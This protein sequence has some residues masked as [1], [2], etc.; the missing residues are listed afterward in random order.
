MVVL[1]Y[2]PPSRQTIGYSKV[3]EDRGPPRASDRQCNS[4]RTIWDDMEHRDR[5]DIR[6]EQ[7][8]SGGELLQLT[9][10]QLAQLRPIIP[11]VPK[12]PKLRKRK[13]AN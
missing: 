3:S 1:I 7:G 13:S 8:R 12:P 2:H 4:E 10:E 9:A 5:D 6:W 11:Y